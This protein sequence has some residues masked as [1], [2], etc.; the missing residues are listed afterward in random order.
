MAAKE[1]RMRPGP[2][3]AVAIVVAVLTWIALPRLASAESIAFIRGDNI[4]IAAPDGSGATQVTTDGTASAPYLHI[5]SVKV[6]DAPPI[7]YLRYDSSGS[8]VY[9]TVRPDGSG[10]APNPYT[11]SM[12]GFTQGNDHELS[13]D[14]AGDRVAWSRATDIGSGQ[15]FSPHSVGLDGSAP[16]EVSRGTTAYN[17]TFGD[18]AGGS[19]LFDDAVG[20]DYSDGNNAANGWPPAPAV[21]SAGVGPQGLVRQVPVAHDATLAA[22]L[23]YYCAGGN[24]GL[25]EP[26]LSPDGQEI[27][28]QATLAPGA[29]ADSRFASGLPRIAV[30]AA[31]AV[32]SGETATPLTLLTPDGL[33]A[34]YPDFSPDHSQVAFSGPDGVYVVPAAG[35]PVTKVLDEAA[36]PAWSSYA[37]PGAAAAPQSSAPPKRPKTKLKVRV[38]RR[39][40][41][42]RFVFAGSGGVGRLHFK[43]KLSRQSK[44]L[45]R[46]RSCS[47]PKVYKRLRKGRHLFEV[48][49]VDSTGRADA[50][51]AK[52]KF[53]I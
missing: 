11:A 3:A 26:A 2:K 9:G 42:A 29:P 10:N 33:S 21:C 4:W 1:T 24:V 38:D 30:F 37:L 5:S 48:K 16:T 47:S 31:G 49:A 43:C 15:T 46:W 32:A 41:Q 13:I 12:P 7:A 35:G 44:K 52:A 39:K 23:A 22:P 17:T 8:F 40:R 51:P 19:L 53:K 14:P 18:P 34:A 20:Y 36:S 45:R 28:A 6:G 25:F 27:A 50:T